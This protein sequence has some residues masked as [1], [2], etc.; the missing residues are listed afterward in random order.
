MDRLFSFLIDYLVISPFVLFFLYLSFFSGFSY[1]KSNPMAEEKDLFYVIVGFSG[2]LYFSLIQSLFI[3]K[4]QAT[5]GQYFLK[6]RLSFSEGKSLAFLRAFFRQFL[7]TFTFVTMAFSGWLTLNRPSPYFALIFSVL[8]ISYLSF[9]TNRQRRTFY[10]QISDVSVVTLKNEK[11]FFDFEI[12][13]R[14]WQS[15]MATLSIF[16]AVLAVIVIA[17]NYDKVLQRAPS[18]AKMQDNGFFC[19]EMNHLNSQDRLGTAVA[20]NLVNQLSDSCLD[21]EADFVLWRQKTE[22]YSLAYYAK[23]LTADN[24]EKEKNYLQQACTG[25]NLL[26]NEKLTMGCRIANAYLSG[27]FED[28]YTQ[29][30]EKN[31]LSEALRYEFSI[32]LGK[33]ADVE[34]NFAALEKYNTLKPVKKFQVLEMIAAKIPTESA[35]A[36]ASFNEN[37]ETQEPDKLLKLVDEL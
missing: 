23:S 24:I 28:L 22:D 13:H 27:K 33:E 35:R 21:R 12:E 18:L 19:E 6:M 8:G 17:G 15:L 37:T 10:D 1:L 31:F 5:P 36:P 4:W 20:L 11:P 2:V 26:E 30:N 29:L 9:M 14:Y 7:G 32:V 25:Q 34:T 16:V 3:F